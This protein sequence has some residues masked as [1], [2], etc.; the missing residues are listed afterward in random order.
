MSALDRRVA[1]LLKKDG[2][3]CHGCRRPFAKGESSTFGFTAGRHLMIVGSCC[4]GK[5]VTVLGFGL[6]L[7]CPP[8]PAPWREDDRAWFEAHPDR[9]HR[10]RRAY[11]RECPGCSHIAVR[12]VQEGKRLRQPIIL[13]DDMPEDAP[14]EPAWAI[15]DLAIEARAKGAEG[16]ASG[17]IRERI[18]LLSGAGTA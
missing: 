10:V 4:T 6:F 16:V 15:F 14:E 1:R 5:L 7:A 9:S 13:P 3:H 12:Q 11:P 18:R 2:E 17:A 8:P